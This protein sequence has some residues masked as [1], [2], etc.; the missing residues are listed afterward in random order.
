MSNKI[1]Y[2]NGMPGSGK[3]TIAKMVANKT[4]A[5]VIDNHKV[6]NLLFDI[7]G[8]N[9][10]VPKFV[11]ESLRVIKKELY[12][13]LERLPQES[14]YIF[15]GIAANYKENITV[16]GILNLAEKLNSEFYCINLIC[17]KKNILDRINTEQRQANKK[18]TSIDLYEEVVKFDTL[19]IIDTG[20]SITIDNSNLTE[21]ETFNKVMEFLNNK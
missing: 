8:F 1:I 3:L 2:F 14:D 7:K 10:E 20:K 9:E 16:N 17:D 18:I 11:W 12:S 21:E 6:N 13:L 4:G 5:K 15:T 19:K